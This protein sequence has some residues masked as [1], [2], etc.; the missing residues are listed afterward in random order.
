MRRAWGTALSAVALPLALGLSACGGTQLSS[1]ELRNRAGRICAAADARTDAIASPGLTGT[2]TFLRQGLAAL[3]PELAELERMR[4]RGA[5]AT[6]YASALSDLRAELAD[7]ATAE[8]SLQHGGDPTVVFPA[9]QSELTPLESAE[10]RAW[11]A[12]GIPG[13]VGG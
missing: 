1:A 2:A 11:H 9:L 8:H 4:P 5:A 7:L 6:V 12:L 3:T 10:N 13:C